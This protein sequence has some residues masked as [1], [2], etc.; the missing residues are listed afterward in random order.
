MQVAGLGNEAVCLKLHLHKIL[1]KFLQ[2]QY[3]LFQTCVLIV[4]VI[5][6]LFRLYL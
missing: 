1:L 6:Y 3:N 5:T 4:L 2:V